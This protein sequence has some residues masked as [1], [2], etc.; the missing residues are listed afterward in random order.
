MLG[1]NVIATSGRAVE[2][3]GDVDVLLLDKTGTITLEAYRQASAF[4][5]A[6]ARGRANPR[7]RRPALLAGGCETPEGAASW[8]W[9]NSALICTN[10]I[11]SRCTPPLSP[12]PRKRGWAAHQYRS[13]HDH[14]KG[15][16]TPFAATWRPTAATSSPMSINGWKRSP[17]RRPTPLVVAE[18]E[19]AGDYCAQR[20]R[21]G[22]IKEQRFAQ[23]RKMGIKTVMITGDNRLTA[24]AAI[25]RR[26][27]GVDDFLAEA[28]RKPSWR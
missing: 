20:Y 12:L 24:H 28:T 13:A 9:R 2:A 7:R 16:W 3:A 23:L 15:R 14:A 10:A 27:H 18:G 19:G 11:C 8:C 26:G 6:R 17:R 25:N 4:L 5:P 21:Q 22:G 1:A